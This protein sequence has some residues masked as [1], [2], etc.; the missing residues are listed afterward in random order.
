MSY[1]L[2]PR[3]AVEGTALTGWDVIRPHIL[4]AAAPWGC[5]VVDCYPGADFQGIAASLTTG[6]SDFLV[7]DTCDL[8]IEEKQRAALLAPFVTEDRVFGYMAPFRMPDLFDPDALAEARAKVRR[9]LHDGKR[10]L[11]VGPGARLVHDGDCLVYADMPRWEIQMRMRNGQQNW[12]V[13]G[14]E[15]DNLKKFKVGY[16]VEWRVADRWKME[17]FNEVDLFLDTT[18]MHTPH[19]VSGSDMRAALAS[20]VT[21]PFRVMP[22]FDP[23]V[24]GGQWMREQFNLPDGPPN[25]AWAFDCVP[26]ENSLLL[27]FGGVDVEVPSLNLVLR[28][29]ESLLGPKV[30]SRFGPDFPIRIDMLDTVQGGNLSLQVHPDTGYAHDRFGMAYTQDE[31]YYILHAEPGA[32]VYLGLKDGANAEA[33]FAALADAQ[34]GGPPLD[35]ERYVNKWPAKTHD[36]FWIPSGTIHCAGAGCLVLEMSATPYIF[37]FKLWDWGRVGIDGLPRPVHAE[38]GARVMREDRNTSWAKAEVIGK[39][40]ILRQTDSIREERTGLHPLEFIETRRHWFSEPVEQNT[41]GSVHVLNLVSGDK[42]VIESPTGA[43]AAYEVGYAET[44]IIPARVGPYRIVPGSPGKEHGIIR[45][46]VRI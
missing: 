24:W 20:V 19:S 22:F 14:P 30:Y 21:R 42:A 39:T 7:I 8:L 16:F 46:S 36:H 28:H 40:E 25:Y 43:F 4:G 13:P 6:Q 29:P 17:L 44:F 45:A 23:G 10:A 27:S 15:T 35:V 41:D 32:H 12:L 33:F 5:I 2:C 9:H 1:D 38:H 37:T 18:H 31:S 3:T 11:V 34:A 26:E